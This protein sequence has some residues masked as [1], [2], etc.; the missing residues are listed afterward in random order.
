MIVMDL[1]LGSQVL[2]LELIILKLYLLQVLGFLNTDI[3]KGKF[4]RLRNGWKNVVPEK[5][6]FELIKRFKY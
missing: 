3:E 1:V 5:K 2:Q 4:Y 6:N